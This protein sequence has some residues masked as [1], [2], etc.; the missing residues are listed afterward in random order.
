M[1]QLNTMKTQNRHKF[2][3]LSTI[4]SYKFV[5]DILNSLETEFS[6]LSLSR[7]IIQ[8][9]MKNNSSGTY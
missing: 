8:S 5:T 6:L 3:L 7:I 1:I 4:L 2:E 9:I